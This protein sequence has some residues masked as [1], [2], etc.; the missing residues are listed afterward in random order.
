MAPMPPAPVV[1]PASPQVPP[2]VS[3]QSPLPESSSTAEQTSSLSPFKLLGK[4][5]GASN[6]LPPPP[7]QPNAVVSQSPALAPVAPAPG[8]P[9]VPQA[10]VQSPQVP[11]QGG[12]LVAKPS[13]EELLKQA[14]EAP[15]ASFILPP[16]EVIAAPSPAAKPLMAATPRPVGAA[17]QPLLEKAPSQPAA[18]VRQGPLGTP[19]APLP[20]QQRPFTPRPGG[21]APT[22]APKQ[23]GTVPVNGGVKAKIPGRVTPSV[24]NAL[25]TASGAGFGAQPK[26]KSIVGTLV[27]TAFILAIVAVG[28]G[29]V[30]ARAGS[31]VPVLYTML[32]G[33]EPTGTG[34]TAQALSYVQAR[35][36][37]QVQGEVELVQADLVDSSGKPQL[38][39]AGDAG[40]GQVYRLKSQIGQGEIAEK[41]V[42]SVSSVALTVNQNDPIQLAMK[43]SPQSG[44]TDNW[45]TYFSSNDAPELVS[46]K[47][48][49][50][51]KTLLLPVLQAIP[52]E[53]LL[54]TPTGELAY[55]KLE[56]TK[57]GT[58][59]AAY[60]FT[61]G[62]DKIKEF[63]PVGAT[64]ENFTLVTRYSWVQG[65]TPAG[66]PVSVDLKGKVTYQQKAYNY[67][68]IW[69]YGN[70]DKALESSEDTS[71]G[72]AKVTGSESPTAASMAS[73]TAQMGILSL[74][75]L[76]NTLTDAE[77]GSTAGGGVITPTGE[78]ITAAGTKIT[79]QPPVP[80]KPAT[81]E[82]KLRDTQRQKD[83]ADIKRALT[84]Y[85]AATGSY[86]VSIA[87]LQTAEGGV[88][89]SELVAK[90]LTK[91]P[92]DPTKTTYWYE[93]TSDGTTFTLRAVAEDTE[94]ATVKKGTVFSY[95]EVTN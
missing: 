69:R 14:A 75:S 46:F 15:A 54:T 51:A 31:R 13:R 3:P 73:A 89:L 63:F 70:W 25:A 6:V 71:G 62:T 43:Q 91:L 27:L 5:D 24:Q 82:A 88:L 85:K 49:L 78:G 18:P 19:S 22:L 20:G 92:V 93:Y 11:Q 74:E 2:P 42:Q 1:P 29:Y 10:Q 41:G 67:T 90:Y 53:K 40:A 23:M 68:A 12:I 7:V 28:A 38:P 4:K 37:Y 55:Q 39:V 61:V 64:L 17:V 86:P 50:V 81:D 66:Q 34:A 76:P 21:T 65:A 94:N 84:A 35:T 72:L 48:S 83:L 16:P 8:Q 79:T 58:A 52:L 87:K 77:G 26:R 95:Y 57:T 47:G 36:R 44:E 56:G 9:Q 30:M 59:I 60:Q 33:L 32:S 80:G 45:K